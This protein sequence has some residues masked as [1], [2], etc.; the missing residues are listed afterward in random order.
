[1]QES[2]RPAR[3]AGLRPAILSPAS[4]GPHASLDRRAGRRAGYC[5]W[6]RC[7]CPYL[8]EPV[9]PCLQ[10]PRQGGATSGCGRSAA[11]IR[12]RRAR[13]GRVR[14]SAT[15]RGWR[16]GAG[17]MGLHRLDGGELR[18]QPPSPEARACACQPSAAHRSRSW[19]AAVR[20]PAPGDSTPGRAHHRAPGTP[21]PPCA[22]VP[23]RVEQDHAG[24]ENPS[25]SSRRRRRIASPTLNSSRRMPEHSEHARISGTS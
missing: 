4:R 2:A 1:M 13:R 15:L 14:R 17:P 8:P 23:D 24:A 21:P 9:A 10:A 22:A 18:W 11:S 6:D 25:R 3:H 7:P 16:R 5:R 20:S 12:P 19:G